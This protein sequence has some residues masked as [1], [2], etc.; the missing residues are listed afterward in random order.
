MRKLMVNDD[1]LTNYLSEQSRYLV[2]VFPRG[3]PAL[4][5]TIQG[6]RSVTKNL[7]PSRVGPH[8]LLAFPH[9]SIEGF[10]Q[11]KHGVVHQSSL[12]L[13]T[14]NNPLITSQSNKPIYRT[15]INIL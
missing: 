6:P 5:S 13:Q 2:S 8:R 3:D 10:D 11:H 15:K 4:S 1:K 14:K 12:C 7:S 9:Q